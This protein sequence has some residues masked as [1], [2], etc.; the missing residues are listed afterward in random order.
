MSEADSGG[1]GRLFACDQPK[2]CCQSCGSFVTA[3]YRRVFGTR[4]GGHFV[5]A[6]CRNC[7]QQYSTDLTEAQ[8]DV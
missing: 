7:T 4:V 8:A 6:G 2:N 5:V 3:A 1:R